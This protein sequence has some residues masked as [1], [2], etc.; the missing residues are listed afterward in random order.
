LAVD[1]TGTT[2]FPVGLYLLA[3]HFF[4]PT[5]DFRKNC[6]GCG[7]YIHALCGRVLEEDE[8]LFPADSVV[9]LGWDPKNQGGAAIIP[10]LEDVDTN[11]ET[12]ASLANMPASPVGG[13]WNSPTCSYRKCGKN[14]TY[15]CEWSLL[16]RANSSCNKVIHRLCFEHFWRVTPLKF[17][18]ADDVVCCAT[19]RCCS[20]FKKQALDCIQWDADGPNGPNSLPNSQ[21]IILDWW[22][23]GINY[24]LFRGGKDENGKTG[25]N[26]KSSVWQYLSDEIKKQGIIVERSPHHVGMKINKMEGE[27]WKTYDWVK[28]TGQGILDEGGDITDIVLKKCPYYYVLEAVMADRPGTDPLV[29]FEAG[30]MEGDDQPEH[31][32]NPNQNSEDEDNGSSTSAQLHGEESMQVV[33]KSPKKTYAN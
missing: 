28:Q 8:G 3:S 9:C 32:N 20:K 13:T 22:T 24:H 7:K 17:E 25:G 19:V 6:P 1:A 33:D 11:K 27:F 12:K 4:A 10:A 21:S 14:C 18:V 5:H 26:K 23:D 15:G 16:P 29:L 2:L 30:L 31:D